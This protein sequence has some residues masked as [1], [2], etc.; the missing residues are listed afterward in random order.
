MQILT[1]TSPVETPSFRERLAAFAREIDADL[2]RFLAEKRRM[3]LEAAPKSAALVDAITHLIE[4]GG[5]RLRPALVHHAY[6]AC[7][8]DDPAAIRPLDLAT[9]LLHAYL[10]IHDDIMDHAELRRGRATTHASFRERHLAAGLHGDAADYGRSMGILVGDLAASYAFELFARTRAKAEHW[11]AVEVSF[12]AM[13]QEVIHGQFMEIDVSFAD[14]EADGTGG[15]GR[16]LPGGARPSAEELLQVLRLKSGRYSVERPV[17]LG[18]LAA[19]ASEA[20][21][22]ALVRYGATLGEAFQLQ[23]DLLGMFG[24]AELVGKPVGGDLAEGKYTFLMHHAFEH[25]EP[26]DRAFL[27]AAR[28]KADLTPEEADRAAEILE[29][30][31]ARR[32]VEEM[33]TERVE[34]AAE[35]LIHLPEAAGD[36]AAEGRA[37]LAGLVLYSR[38]RQH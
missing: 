19:G 5:K 1:P 9:E 35:S 26:E 31:G 34:E 8:G 33:V 21:L 24:D 17:E 3:A 18:A 30:C 25:A 10:L 38:E 15:T 11:S 27:A 14:P 20:S 12:A 37:F 16:E 13:A 6:L 22:A 4:G 23:D 36:A 7:G 2:G 32:R 29:R 28:G